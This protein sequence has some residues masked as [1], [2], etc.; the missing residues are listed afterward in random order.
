[1][2]FLLIGDDFYSNENSIQA[3]NF[4]N[5]ISFDASIVCRLKNDKDY[6]KREEIYFNYELINGTK[7]NF[8]DLFTKDADLYTI[9]RKGFYRILASNDAYYPGGY[10]DEK[11]DE[12]I[13]GEYVPTITEYDI[14][15]KINEFMNNSCN[16]FY[17]NSQRVYL[18]GEYYA[19][20]EFKDIADEV[21]IYNKYLTDESIYEKNDIGLKNIW[22]CA[23]PCSDMISFQEYGFLEDN[24]YY[25]ITECE[26][27][28]P[29]FE[30]Y[31][32][33]D[34]FTRVLEENRKNAF[35][36]VEKYRSIAK[37]NPNNFYVFLV[38]PSVT[39]IVQQKYVFETNT[40]NNKYSNIISTGMTG[41]L[42]VA[43][44]EN[45]KENTMNKL[46]EAY[47]YYNISFY[48][49]L[50]MNLYYDENATDINVDNIIYNA[51]TE[52]ETSIKEIF[53]ENV[54]YEEILNLKLKEEIESKKITSTSEEL[55]TLIENAKFYIDSNFIYAKILDFDYYITL[56]SF[57]SS[58][59][60]N[61][62]NIY[63]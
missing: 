54:D 46:L 24:F 55:N 10:Y 60:E 5:V 27:Y 25:D 1:M 53:R 6:F 62:L 58:E 45:A 16:P 21:T 13:E 17:F 33:N 36:E 7:L 39:P 30:N 50:V 11:R 57:S 51:K 35:E 59:A 4:S 9:I 63:D 56:I 26:Y 47:R 29:S 18:G 40:W 19:C 44:G 23:I 52:K 32:Y 41:K 2:T 22:T 37:E 12:W 28:L 34:F 48:S 42:I 15:K 14:D 38:S 8:A 61:L 20:I 49:G 31:P 3:A 43:S